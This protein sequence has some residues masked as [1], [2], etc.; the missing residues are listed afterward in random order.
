MARLKQD[1]YESG[2][3]FGSRYECED[4]D[5]GLPMHAHTPVTGGDHNVICLRG[6]IIIYGDDWHHV[7]KAG[8][9]FDFDAT[10]RHGIVPMNVGATFLNL[11]IIG[12]PASADAMT[13][14]QKHTVLDCPHGA[15]EWVLKLQKGEQ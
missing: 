7:L 6:S 9:V 5:A 12:R 3:L 14:D 1:I 13:Y 15:P 11:S 10:L 2:L 4:L 8:D